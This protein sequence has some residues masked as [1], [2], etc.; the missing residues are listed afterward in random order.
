M[1]KLWGQGTCPSCPSP[2]GV[3]EQ[4]VSHSPLTSLLA[5]WF[6]A[7][8]SREGRTDADFRQVCMLPQWAHLSL[9]QKCRYPVQGHR[10][11]SAPVQ[12]LRVL[13]VCGGSLRVTGR[14]LRH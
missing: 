7:W 1:G 5:K 12:A 8:M 2:Q 10:A 3:W 9:F 4:A 6:C 14:E 13:R 11:A